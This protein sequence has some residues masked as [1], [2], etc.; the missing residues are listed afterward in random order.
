MEIFLKSVTERSYPEDGVRYL[1]ETTWPENVQDMNLSPYR[2]I[3]AW[4]PS[5]ELI[6]TAQKDK[7][8]K[9]HFQ[10]LYRAELEQPEAQWAIQNFLAQGHE[11]VTF[12]YASFSPLE[13]N[14]YY[15]Q[16]HIYAYLDSQLAPA[17]SLAA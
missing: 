14:A 11:R 7:W 8:T 1:I 15:L 12:L 2:W 6:Q 5:Y 4:V 9:E 17:V 16:K 3:R 13:S 10:Y